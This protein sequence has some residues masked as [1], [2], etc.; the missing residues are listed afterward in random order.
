M[1]YVGAKK[2]DEDRQRNAQKYNAHGDG[3]IGISV[4]TAK[5]D[6][7]DKVGVKRKTSPLI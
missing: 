3:E 7:A 1:R 4:R 5:P 6:D 2:L